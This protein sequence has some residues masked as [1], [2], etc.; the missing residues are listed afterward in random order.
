MRQPPSETFA[1]RVAA[2]PALSDYAIPDGYVPNDEKV[3]YP[4]FIKPELWGPAPQPGAG[5]ALGDSGD[6]GD[7]TA[8]SNQGDP[9]EST[10]TD[11][12]DNDVRQLTAAEVAVWFAEALREVELVDKDGKKDALGWVVNVNLDVRGLQQVALLLTWSLDGLDVPVSWSAAQVAYRLIPTTAHDSGSIS[13]WVPVL[14]TPG[15]YNV[16]VALAYES[17]GNALDTSQAAIPNP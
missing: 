3:W 5:K 10:D 9:N 7:P 4:P 1:A 11:P 17:D 6:Q 15:V 12:T 14:A 8:P 13:V 2:H 16:N